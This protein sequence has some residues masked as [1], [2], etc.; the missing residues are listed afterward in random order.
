ML[1]SYYKDS[2]IAIFPGETGYR[3]LQA[4]LNQKKKMFIYFQPKSPIN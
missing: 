3:D 4:L 1:K 2:F